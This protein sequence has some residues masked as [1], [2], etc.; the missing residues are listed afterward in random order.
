MGTKYDTFIAKLKAK[1]TPLGLPV[2]AAVAKLPNATHI[3]DVV[4]TLAMGG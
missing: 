1:A 3:S 4:A 2:T